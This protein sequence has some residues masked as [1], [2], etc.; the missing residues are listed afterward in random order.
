MT[1]S[2]LEG[3]LYLTDCLDL[4]LIGRETSFTS[5]CMLGAGQVGG[6]V[7]TSCIIHSNSFAV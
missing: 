5:N 1:L 4:E 3:H 6:A 2:C 7:P